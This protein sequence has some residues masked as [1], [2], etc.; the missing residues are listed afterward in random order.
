MLNLFKQFKTDETAE[1]KG[2]WR[3]FGEAKFLIARTGNKAYAK[4]LQE[5]VEKNRSLLNKKGEAADKLSESIMIEVTAKTLLLGWEGIANPD[6]EEEALPFSHEAAIAFLSAEGM[7]DFRKQ[8]AA[9]AD[10]EEEYRVAKL[11]E[12]RKN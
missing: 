9:W 10:D 11:E 12:A 5:L 6:N 7:K 3:E 1:N 2:V 4:L 8:I